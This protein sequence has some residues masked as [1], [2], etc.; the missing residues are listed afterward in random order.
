MQAYN[1]TTNEAR[2]SHAQKLASLDSRFKPKVQ[3]LMAAMMRRDFRPKIFYAYRRPETQLELYRK[4]RS[5][6]KFSF[7]NVRT[8]D[9]RA[10]AALGADIVDAQK[11]WNNPAFFKALGEEAKKLNLYW[12]GDWKFK[13]SAHVQLLPNSKL[14]QLALAAGVH[15]GNVPGASSHADEHHEAGSS[16]LPLLMV[17]G[18]ALLAVASR[19]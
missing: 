14:A 15:Q 9:N 19:R 4:G 7:H 13:D 10:P 6:V 16:I 2:W 1:W 17:A 12:G 11:G 18:L 8:S 3:L 5:Q